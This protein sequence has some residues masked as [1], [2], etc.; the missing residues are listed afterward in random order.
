MLETEVGPLVTEDTSNVIYANNVVWYSKVKEYIAANLRLKTAY[1]I[2]NFTAYDEED[3]EYYTWDK[4]CKATIKNGIIQ[5]YAKGNQTYEHPHFRWPNIDAFNAV[6]E[7]DGI[8]VSI[9][10]KKKQLGWD[11]TYRMFLLYGLWRRIVQK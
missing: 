5:Y 9:T 4:E 8:K 2:V 3:G 1:A 7:I 6:I 11:H 10:E